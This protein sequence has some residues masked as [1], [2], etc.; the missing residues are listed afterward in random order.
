MCITCKYPGCSTRVYPG[1]EFCGRTHGSMYYQLPSRDRD[2]DVTMSTSTTTTTTS[3]SSAA[4]ICKLQGCSN[5]VY[6]GSEFCSRTHVAQ[7][8]EWVNSQQQPM[9]S[10]TSTTSTAIPAAQICKFT[11]CTRPASYPYD[12]CTKTHGQHYSTLSASSSS[13][14]SP[15][16]G[17]GS[18][19]AN[20]CKLNGCNNP[21]ASGYDYCTKKHAVQDRK[22]FASV[23]KLDPSDPE[24][25]TVSDQ[26][27]SKWHHPI[28]KKPCGVIQHILKVN[29][30]MDVVR[31]FE[32]KRSEIEAV[33]KFVSKK[34]Q[35]GKQLKAGNSCRRFH[36]TKVDCGLGVRG[37]S[38]CRS[39]KCNVCRIVEQSFILPT[40]NSTNNFNNF[41]RFGPGIYFSSVSSKSHDYTNGGTGYKYMFIADVLVGNGEKLY[42]DHVTI[43]S[44][45]AGFDSVLGET[46]Q[47][48]NYDECIV[49]N[50]EQAKPC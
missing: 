49:Y 3:S 32:A 40:Q 6:A 26:F 27:T 47:S 41:L 38:L 44:P 18:P 14:G 30:A 13:S 36:G 5:T 37:M 42:N 48:L 8:N 15:T 17:V 22:N 33:G 35:N 21:R 28:S 39:S 9:T 10:T 16:T 43:K 23:M 34:Q 24:F 19:A 20:F 46:G 1:Y 50:V 4:T 29:P 7:Y 31:R 45:S 2:T 25:K 12:F 11:G